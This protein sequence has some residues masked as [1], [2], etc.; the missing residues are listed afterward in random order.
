MIKSILFNLLLFGLLFSQ[1]YIANLVCDDDAANTTISNDG[2][3]SNWIASANTADLH[4]TLCTNSYYLNG[5]S[6]S[7]HSA[8]NYTISRISISWTEYFVNATAAADEVHLQ[9]GNGSATCQENGWILL[10]K[11]GETQFTFICM[12]NGDAT[13]DTIKT[14]DLSSVATTCSDFTMVIDASVSP[15][16]ISITK[17]EVPLTFGSWARGDVSVATSISNPFYFGCTGLQEPDTAI[18]NILIWETPLS[19]NNIEEVNNKKF[20]KYNLYKSYVD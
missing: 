15:W 8:D 3:G 11:A 5:N 10:R 13:P 1:T 4:S 19:E 6:E 12:G 9:I 20:N 16:T 2:T 17:D 18:G 14:T 7:F